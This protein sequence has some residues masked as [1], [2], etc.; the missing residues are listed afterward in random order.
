[1]SVS[2]ELFPD[3]PILLV[4]IEGHLDAPMVHELYG[5]IGELTEGMEAPIYRI[6]DVRKL[7]TSFAEVLGIIK[8]AMKDS[9]GTTTD[10]R[11]FNI[12]VGRDKMAMIARDMLRRINPDNHPLLDSIEDA[13]T[14]IRWKLDGADSQVTNG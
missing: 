5:Q 1:M 3:E 4:T 14:Y 6:T 12:F 2:V 10:P 8:E 11:I 9:P 13:L 7:E